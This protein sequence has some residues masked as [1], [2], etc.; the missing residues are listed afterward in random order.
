MQIFLASMLKKCI[1]SPSEKLKTTNGCHSFPRQRVSTCRVVYEYCPEHR[2][3]NFFLTT[4][5]HDSDERISTHIAL[6]RNTHVAAPFA[7]PQLSKIM[8]ESTLDLAN[9]DLDCRFVSQLGS[10]HSA[11]L[12]STHLPLTFF[13]TVSS[14][15]MLPWPFVLCNAIN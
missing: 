12:I 14:L 5:S 11:L 1:V 6:E 4:R 8:S 7:R 2:I 10:T 13:P 9:W 3:T 15:L